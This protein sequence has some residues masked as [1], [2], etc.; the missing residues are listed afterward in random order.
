MPLRIEPV[1][2]AKDLH[3]F[4]T[5]PWTLYRNDPAWVA[6][7]IGDTKKIFDPKSNPFCEHGEIEPYLAR[8]AGRVGGRI[9]AIRNRIHE[10]F[11]NEPVGFFG[12]F[13]CDDNVEVAMGLVSTVRAWL[14]TRNLERM[15]GPVNPSTND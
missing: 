2:D 8:M 13:E 3:A 5:Y 15:Q 9:A 12:F 6:P 10:E 1:R 4:V 11:H 7:L 14:R